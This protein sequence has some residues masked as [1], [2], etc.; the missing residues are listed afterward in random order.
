MCDDGIHFNFVR[1]EDRPDNSIGTEMY[2]KMAGDFEAHGD[3][4]QLNPVSVVVGKAP[5][6]N[7]AVRV[8]KGGPIERKYIARNAK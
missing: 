8:P 5:H 1:A 2:L 7:P 3:R 4:P 6:G